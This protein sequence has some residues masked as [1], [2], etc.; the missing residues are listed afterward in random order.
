MRKPWIGTIRG[1]P[2]ANRG[3]TFC[4]TTHG[5][6]AQTVDPRFAPHIARC[7]KL[8]GQ[9]AI[10]CWAGDNPWIV[11][12]KRGSMSLRRAIHELSWIH[13]LHIKYVTQ[14]FTSDSRSQMNTHE[15][16]IY[17]KPNVIRR[18]NLHQSTAL[19]KL[20]KT[21]EAHGYNSWVP[22]LTIVPSYTRYTVY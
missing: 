21:L 5:L 4:A 15:Q 13:T 17:H 3:S 20:Q 11:C 9:D 12:A 14:V 8:K 1:L 22:D 18:R 2:C 10:T 19:V 7:H 16:N 6:S